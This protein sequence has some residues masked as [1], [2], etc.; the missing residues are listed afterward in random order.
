MGVRDQKPAASQG[1]TAEVI[2]IVSGIPYGTVLTYGEVAE[3]AGSPRA[4]R[5]VV[6]VLTTQSKNHQ[7]PW[8]RVVGKG[9]EIR[10]PVTSG[11]ALQQSLLEAEGWEI[12]EMKRLYN[13]R[14]G[15]KE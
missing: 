7:L 15:E 6:R 5:Q 14:S 1:F 10:L 3:L 12:Q 8:H 2:R 13:V 9:S 4:S 11:G